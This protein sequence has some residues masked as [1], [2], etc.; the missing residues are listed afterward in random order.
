[1]PLT[2]WEILI[3]LITV[4]GGIG[5]QI[6]LSTRKSFWFGLILPMISIGFSLYMV[7]RISFYKELEMQYKLGMYLQQNMLTI[8]LL[9]IFGICQWRMHTKRNAS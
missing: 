2:M 1:M 9:L 4:F 3:V 8:G 6:W 5:I 7:P